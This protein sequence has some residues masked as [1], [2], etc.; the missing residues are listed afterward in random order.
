MPRTLKHNSDPA[1]YQN[2]RDLQGTCIDSRVLQMCHKALCATKGVIRL[3][4]KGVSTLLYWHMQLSQH[5]N[6]GG[7][8]RGGGGQKAKPGANIRSHPAFASMEEASAKASAALP[9]E[10]G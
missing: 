1:L 9:W 3:I 10:R 2:P 6:Q 5:S 8:G 4:H 7:Q